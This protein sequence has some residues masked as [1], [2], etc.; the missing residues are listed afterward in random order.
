[1]FTGSTYRSTDIVLE[2]GD[3]LVIVTDGMLER[4]AADLDLVTTLTTMAAMHP[5]E[6]TRAL[7]DAVLELTGGALADDAT[8][9]VLDWHGEHHRDR[10]SVAGADR[11]RLGADLAHG[12]DR[13]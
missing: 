13:W 7:A 1:M 12:A 3:R 6:A 2:P 10:S 8:M 5:R 9:L 4:N 11:R